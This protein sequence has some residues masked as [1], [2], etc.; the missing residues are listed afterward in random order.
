METKLVECKLIRALKVGSD[1][2]TFS[3]E[4]AA[5]LA[6]SIKV[7]G[8]MNPIIIRPNPA[9]PGEYLLVA[10]RHRLFATGKVLKEQFIRATIQADMTE[11]EAEIAA[12]VENL[13][14]N[15]L[16]R[17]QH[18][19][20]LKRWH[21]HWLDKM[22]P[23]PKPKAEIDQNDKSAVEGESAEPVA[24]AKSEAD[25][26]KRVAA[27]TG[28][29]EATVRRAKGIAKAFTHEQL[30]VLGMVGAKQA[31]MLTIAKIKDEGKR[32]EVVNLIASGIDI[33][34][35]IE[36]VMGAEAP[37]KYNETK[38]ADETKK[39]AK[40]EKAP[41]LTADEWFE[42]NC[43]EKAAMLGDP[44]RYKADA[45]L[46]RAVSDLRRDHRSKA[47]SIVAAT[48]AGGVTG[49]FFNLIH[50]YLSVSHPRDWLLCPICAAKGVIPGS[51]S[52]KP[53]TKCAKCYGGGYS[54]KTEE[55]I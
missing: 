36:T 47:K 30:E 38:E 16:N 10:G 18:A 25:F 39:A 17:A 42:Q 29:S 24:D 55:Y 20:A 15:P 50:R 48:K 53:N 40:A 52:S 6:D 9:T 7:D 32:G 3:K 14:R 35:A 44:A 45:L 34:Q 49:P 11:E 28:Q 4:F 33:A 5:K 8:L 46:Y 37:T 54:T 41:E 27:A 13:W 23:A 43:G 19:G 51:D 12:D 21:A 31:E 22:T 26:D 2:R 1:K